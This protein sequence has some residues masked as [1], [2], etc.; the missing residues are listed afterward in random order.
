MDVKLPLAASY[1]DFAKYDAM[2]KLLM[3]HPRIIAPIL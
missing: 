2:A 3:M 1:G